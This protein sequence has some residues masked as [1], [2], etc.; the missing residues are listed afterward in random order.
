MTRNFIN[1]LDNKIILQL[2]EIQLCC[3][4]QVDTDVLSDVT[5]QLKVVLVLSSKTSVNWQVNLKTDVDLH[6]VYLVCFNLLLD[7]MEIT[8]ADPGF[9]TGRATTF[10]KRIILKDR[11]LIGGQL[12]KKIILKENL[13]L[14][15]TKGTPPLEPPLKLL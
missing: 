7:K 6:H 4:F 2:E 5:D 13:V 14:G 15:R 11:I 12:L 10:F 8:G 9:L 3:I 1:K